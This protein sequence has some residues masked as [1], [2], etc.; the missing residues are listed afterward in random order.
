MKCATTAVHAWISRHPDVEGGFLKETYYWNQKTLRRQGEYRANYLLKTLFG[1]KVS[2]DGTPQYF[3]T[4][5][6]KQRIA[7]EVSQPKM[8]VLLREPVARTISS[9]L[10]ARVR[11]WTNRSF[12][13]E[14]LFEK[15]EFPSPEQVAQTWSPS[16]DTFLR[17]GHGWQSTYAWQIDSTPPAIQVLILFIEKFIND[18]ESKW[19]KISRFLNL[20]PVEAPVLPSLNVSP[21]RDSYGPFPVPDWLQS[22]FKQDAQELL[23]RG[24]KAPWLTHL[25]F[26][27]ACGI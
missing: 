9:Y 18:P 3:C 16:Y 1:K 15:K 19:E 10:H 27:L 17:H 21:P 8:I 5:F 26:F 12:E 13:E 22:R 2:L 7:E 11:G 23:R 4:P 25:A 24:L 6:A 20:R 14:L